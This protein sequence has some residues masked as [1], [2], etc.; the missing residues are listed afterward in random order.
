[1][2]L[3]HGG[4]NCGEIKTSGRISQLDIITI[5]DIYKLSIKK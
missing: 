3:L 1:L 4:L 5:S 2:S